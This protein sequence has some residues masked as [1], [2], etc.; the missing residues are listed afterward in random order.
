VDADDGAPDESSQRYA[1]LFTHHPHAAY[2]VDRDGYYTDANPLALAMT[3]LTLEQMRQTHF[4]EV[5]LPEDVHLIQDGFDRAMTGTP[6]VV[7]A[8]VLRTDGEVVDIRCTAIP[9]VVGGQVIG[10][11][12]ISEDVT[13]AKRL[14]RQLEEANAAKTL[15][16]ATVSHE[17]RTPLAVLVGATDLLLDADLE[18]EPEHYAQLV[19]R[20][21]MRLMQ[22]VED[23]LEFSGLDARQTALHPRPFS[24][25]S[26]VSGIADWA[27]PVAE[28]RR[29]EL[30]VTVDESVPE[31][32]V[33]DALRITQV[34]SNLVQNAIDFTDCGGVDVLVRTAGGEPGGWVEF[35]VAD[36]GIGIAED[37]LHSLFHPFTQAEPH[38]ENCQRGT[39][40]GLAIC[41]QLVD[42]MGGRLDVV[43]TSGAGSTFTFG[44]PLGHADALVA[45]SVDA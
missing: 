10:V 40:L 22:L 27:A 31:T 43:S 2:S 7:E 9:V 25:R 42:L 20:S 24:V 6:Q 28:E 33:G 45:A 38:A 5:I 39:G 13:E 44:V 29:L 19:H 34:V 32:S 30:S 41:R 8:R 35:I 15:F 17:V 21:S 11:H 12:G 37:H 18:P 1:S 26:V 16:L 4:S 3:G 23:M 36:T 14:V